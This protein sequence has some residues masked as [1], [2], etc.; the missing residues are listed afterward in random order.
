MVHH[1]EALRVKSSRDDFLVYHMQRDHTRAELDG[2]DL[3]ML[4]YALKLNKTP[5]A[6]TAEDVQALRDAGFDDR[7]VLDIVLVTARYNFMNRLA[8]GLG[9]KPEPNFVTAKERGDRRVEAALQTATP[10][11]S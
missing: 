6:I 1:G 11:Q 5:A 2:Q 8:D 10:A 3:A 4:E 9:V 7:G